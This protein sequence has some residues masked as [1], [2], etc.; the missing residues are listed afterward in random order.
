[1]TCYDTDMKGS[2]QL[3][4][5]VPCDTLDVST[6]VNADSAKEV[7][8]GKTSVK[9]IAFY[10]IAR[11]NTWYRITYVSFASVDW[12]KGNVPLAGGHLQRIPKE[13]QLSQ[14]LIELVQFNS[15][16][17]RCCW[18]GTVSWA[19]RDWQQSISRWLHSVASPL[20]CSHNNGGSVTESFIRIKFFKHLSSL[21]GSLYT[22]IILC[23]TCLHSTI[24][25]GKVIQLHITSQQAKPRES[26]NTSAVHLADNNRQ[27][28]NPWCSSWLASQCE[29]IRHASWR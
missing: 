25:F 20:W 2:I 7:I 10:P 29:D 8:G 6:Q 26:S 4:S 16:W 12:L 22:L 21:A 5:H 11:T 1:M 24:H 27:A 19:A 3:G 23:L 28:S 17:P 18:P 15:C 13:I 9:Q 14:F